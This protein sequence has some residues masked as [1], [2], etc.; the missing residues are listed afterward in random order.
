MSLAPGAR[1]GA[2]EII[3]LIGAGGMGEVY[4]ARDMRLGRDVAIKVVSEAFAGD[5]ERRVRFERE[6]KLISQLN[7]PNI[8]GLYHIADAPNPQSLIPNP[9][10]VQFLVLELVDGP[11]LADRIGQ[12][13][14][15][16]DE[17]LPIARQI[18]DAL[19][20]AH[21]H[22]IVHRDLKPANIKVTPD[23]NVKVL[24]FGLAKA[25]DAGS[26]LPSPQASAGKQD[27]AYVLSNSPTITSPANTLGG[28]ILGTAAYMSPEQ[29]KGKPVDRRTDMWAFGCVLFEMLTGRRAFEGEDVSDTLAEIL[30]TEPDLKRLPPDTP[31]AIARLLRRCLAKDR[32]ARLSDAGVARLEIDEAGS[33]GAEGPR[34]PVAAR[35]PRTRLAAAVVLT[36]I[37]TAAI[38][39]AIAFTLRSDPPR[40][41][42]RFAITLG[43]DRQFVGAGRRWLALSPDGSRL[44]YG[45]N[46]LQMRALDS[47][48]TTEIAETNGAMSPFFSPDGRW[49]AFWQNGQLKK[50]ELSGGPPMRLCET[51]LPWGA[52]WEDDG[53]IWFAKGVDGIWK[54][55]ADGGEPV[56]VIAMDNKKG[57]MAESPQPLP[58]GHAVLFTLNSAALAQSTRAQIESARLVVQSLRTGERTTIVSG[59]A[60]G[61]YLPTGHIVYVRQGTLVA[62]PFDLDRLAVTG[63]PMQLVER[64]V[65][66]SAGGGVSSGGRSTAGQYTLS[67]EGTLAYVPQAMLA[68]ERTLVWVDRQGKE[69]PIAA[70]PRAYVYPRISPDGTRIALDVRDQEQD[71][72]VW[73]ISRA[74]LTRLTFDP[75]PDVGPV[76][77]PDGRRI[78]FAGVG[79]GVFWHAADGTG[80]SQPLLEEKARL[81]APTTFTPDGTRLIID[82]NQG[83]AYGIKMLGIGADPSLKTLL[84]T[85]FNEQNAM[86]SPDGRWMAYQSNESGQY[87]IYV[88]PFPD[89]QAGRWQISAS[90]GTRPTWRGREVFY[91]GPAPSMMAVQVNT[92]NGFTYGNAAKLF[93]GPYLAT[94]LGRTYDVSAD[95]QRFLMIKTGGAGTAGTG[96]GQIVVVQNWVEELKRRTSAAR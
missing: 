91:L 43:S 55:P 20:A 52:T 42:R 60:D 90:G 37:V 11:T 50:R 4:R 5:S 93:S 24:D 21:E 79:R 64:I 47:L 53:A 68:P 81:Y 29:A 63:S 33:A 77:S 92:E 36:A 28:V 62:V 76:W 83:A 78:A 30:K 19:E 27:P 85:S 34:I 31:P 12:G 39:A 40:P 51:P 7:H 6:A 44:V 23:G 17:A 54:V 8:C 2:Y 87:E 32:K 84:D 82:E 14:L 59:G 16:L 89:V 9:E 41:V 96:I 88:R 25:M 74:I 86:V 15:P 49:I 1:L 57:E 70:P 45:A 58:G 73:D 75:G 65:Q 18:A 48:E 94:V 22:G 71:I 46:Q 72:Q 69:T 38:A 26:A 10:T 61:R 3:A 56:Q 66:G 35:V 80:T 13:P 67:S 95:G